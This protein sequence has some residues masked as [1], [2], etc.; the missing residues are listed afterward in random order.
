M[1]SWEVSYYLLSHALELSIKAVA[2]SKT[3]KE[4]A[5]IHDKEELADRYRAECQFN[6]RELD[7]VRRLKELNN[8]PGGL[9]YENDAQGK[10]LPS[11]FESGVAIIE[12]LLGTLTVTAIEYKN[13]TNS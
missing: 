3:G 10:F 2:Q 4:P 12:R 11:V 5:R 9:R 7:I 1:G 13:E 6:E 8:G